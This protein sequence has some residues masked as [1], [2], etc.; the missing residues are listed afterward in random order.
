[1]EVR[2]DVKDESVLAIVVA[3][4]TS[5]GNPVSSRFIASRS[6]IK[7]SS[8]TV[9]NICQKL[10]D[11]EYLDKPHRNAGNIPTVKAIKYYVE[12]ILT[13]ASA[14]N[15]DKCG[16]NNI[17]S[18]ELTDTY[19]YLMEM[20]EFLSFLINQ[21]GLI[22]VIQPQEIRL[23][24]LDAVPLSSSALSLIVILSDG[25]TRSITFNSPEI[26]NTKRI[27]PLVQVLN[28]RLHGLSLSEIRNTID[29]R[30][31]D[32]RGMQNKFIDL[33]IDSAFKVFDEPKSSKKVFPGDKFQR[34]FAGFLPNIEKLER[35]I[36]DSQMIENAIESLQ[37]EKPGEVKLEQDK[38]SE[39]YL[40]CSDFYSNDGPGIIGFIGSINLPY[41]RI[42]P[43]IRYAS[44]KFTR[45][46]TNERK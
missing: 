12:N 31:D 13:D 20:G 41:R 17:I 16:I 28:E 21:L 4:F 44:T 5:T 9:R 2:L 25:S 18:S 29:K 6:R 26:G 34:D 8:A 10:V 30:L 38:N 39:L 14:S 19:S 45:Y 36:D 43:V 15:Q 3:A 1:M 22:V 35:A 23:H 46:F 37:G 24:R 40:V 7:M 32:I 27:L 42:V 33:L 11:L